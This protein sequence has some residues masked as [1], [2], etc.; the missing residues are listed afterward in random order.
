MKDMEHLQLAGQ[1]DSDVRNSGPVGRTDGFYD[2]DWAT[3]GK[4]SLEVK[5]IPGV[6]MD[7]VRRIRRE[8]ASGTYETP[9]RIEATVD[10]LV[11]ELY[12]EL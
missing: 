2:A 4:Q 12:P 1:P 5:S 7:L 10:R 8:I 6:R 11:A 3:G 9:E